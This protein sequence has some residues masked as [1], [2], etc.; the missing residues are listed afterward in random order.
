MEYPILKPIPIKTKGLSYWKKL[1]IWATSSRKF[2]VIEDYYFYIPWLDIT[3]KIPKGFIFDGASIPKFLWPILSPTGI[4]FI[5]GLF[6]DYGYKYNKWIDENDNEI[7]IGKGQ[8]FFDIN[9]GKLGEYIN[10][11]KIL[12]TVAYRALRMFGWKAWND[13]RKK[14]KK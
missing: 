11:M 7:Y 13:H 6:H 4:L 3:I 2:E 10:D 5:P 1:W 8:K 14:E 9:F 12:D